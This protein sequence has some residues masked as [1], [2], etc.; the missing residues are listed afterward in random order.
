M[1][2]DWPSETIRVLSPVVRMIPV[3]ARLIYLF[4]SLAFDHTN[5]VL[6]IGATVKT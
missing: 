4:R 5:D 1:D 3:S 2:Q 6:R